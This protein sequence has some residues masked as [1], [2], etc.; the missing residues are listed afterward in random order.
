MLLFSASPGAES[1]HSLF[2]N[3]YIVDLLAMGFEQSREIG[4]ILR[5]LYNIV[6]DNPEMNTKE[7]LTEIVENIRKK[8]LKHRKISSEVYS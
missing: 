4:I 5:E 8:V 7:K 1:T 6:L 2:I 3:C